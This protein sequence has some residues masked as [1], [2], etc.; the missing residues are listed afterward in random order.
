M[1]S[2]LETGKMGEHICMVTLMK[3]GVACEIVNLQTMDIVAHVNGQML[4]VQVKTSM[5]KR[6][7]KTR[8][9]GGAP[10]YQFA[11]SHSGKKKPLDASHCDIIAFVA[12]ELEK[13]LFM[14]ISCFKGQVTK[15]F[16]PSKFHKD[17]V[18][19]RSWEHCLDTI[20]LSD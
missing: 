4:R 17:N 13:V 5:L 18:S 3:L 1:A 6:N 14:P 15:R 11:T 12:L 20:F 19:S 9:E 7:R 8:Y 10:G 2:N 16:P